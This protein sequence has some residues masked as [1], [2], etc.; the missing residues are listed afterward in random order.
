MEKDKNKAKLVFVSSSQID[1]E[2][3]KDL[4][5]E[6]KENLK[7]FLVKSVEKKKITITCVKEKKVKKIRSVN[8]KCPKGYKKK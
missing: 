7:N 1:S 5:K 4:I 6:G 3:Y 8:P 2:S